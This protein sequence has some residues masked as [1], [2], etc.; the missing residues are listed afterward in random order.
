MKRF[1]FPLKWDLQ[2]L[3]RFAA[4]V[5]NRLKCWDHLCCISKVS[6]SALYQVFIFSGSSSQHKFLK[7]SLFFALT[8]RRYSKERNFFFL[9]QGS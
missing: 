1:L 8:V 4:Y 2:E 5:S 7:L 9:A 3:V 6:C